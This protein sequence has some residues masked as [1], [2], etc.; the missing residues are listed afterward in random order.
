M[1]EVKKK[2]SMNGYVEKINRLAW[3]VRRALGRSENDGT[4][5]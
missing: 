5:N 3:L 1:K 4:A 2:D